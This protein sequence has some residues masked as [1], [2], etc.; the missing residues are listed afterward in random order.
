MN[1]KRLTEEKD[2]LGS[3]F[4]HTQ[5]LFHQLATML[6][7]TRLLNSTQHLN[8]QLKLVLEES[9][10]IL[11]V[12]K[13]IFYLF[14]E[15]NNEIWSHFISDG[16]IRRINYPF[17]NGIIRDSI[18][19][20]QVI[21]VDNKNRNVEL[22]D[23]IIKEGF[24]ELQSCMIVPIVNKNRKA[25]GCLQIINKNNCKF[26]QQD[27]LY[28]KIVS[29]LISIAIQDTMMFLEFQEGKRLEKEFEEYRT[30]LR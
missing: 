17:N 30:Y 22:K 28:V 9:I 5:N 12:E 20:G 21:L 1:N 18:K 13:A 7:L 11:Q 3:K 24:P 23:R 27:S 19:N 4:W 10:K 16:E 29:D 25:K 8:H 15:R 26:E 14:N 6:R 2:L